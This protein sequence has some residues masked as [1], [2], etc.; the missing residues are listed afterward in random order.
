MWSVAGKPVLEHCLEDIW[1]A[2][3][4]HA[5]V[6]VARPAEPVLQ[7]FGAGERLG[8]RLDWLPTQGEQRPSDLLGATFADDDA[9]LVCRGD[10]MR[11]RFARRLVERAA[12]EHPGDLHAVVGDRPA[13]IAIIA[14]RRDWADELAWPRLRSGQPLPSP[15]RVHRSNAG[16]ALLDTL[17]ELHASVLQ[18]LHGRFSG[19]LPAGRVDVDSDT[20]TGP[21]ARL[22]ST[23]LIDGKVRIGRNAIVRD[24]VSITG[25][26]DIGQD[27]VIDVGA[28]IAD[29]VVMPG[30]YVGRG[31]RLR[32]ALVCGPWLLRADLGSCKEV[33]DPQLLARVIGRTPRLVQWASRLLRPAPVATS[34]ALS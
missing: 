14:G 17:E 23:A 24:H 11:G 16:V 22:A 19:T 21:R 20:L 4:R 10:V 5:V 15:V 31:V 32:N 34:S 30:T 9:V 1:E 29:S 33:D 26:V 13:G 27:S 18:A 7:A 6:A 3:I 12:S 8:L 2:G 28:E 25:T